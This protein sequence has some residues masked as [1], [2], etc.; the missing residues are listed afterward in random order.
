L[1]SIKYKLLFFKVLLLCF[2]SAIFASEFSNI[3]KKIVITGKSMEILNSGNILISKG[4]SKAVRG[5]N[6]LRA[7]TMIYDKKKSIV[8]A[9]GNV[10]LSGKTE[11]NSSVFAEGDNAVYDEK[12]ETGKFFGKKVLIKY[13]VKNS[14][15]P[16]TLSAKKIVID[17]KK[18][19]ITAQTDVEIITSSGTIRSDNAV[20]IKKSNGLIFRKAEKRPTVNAIYEDKTGDY[21][22]D[23]IV[24][25]NSSA[26]KKIVMSGS[27][28][29][30]IKIGE[31]DEK[32]EG[33]EILPIDISSNSTSSESIY[34]ST[35]ADVE[36][37]LNE[38]KTG[39]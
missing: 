29:G 24:L 26:A 25:Y 2:C 15:Q 4:N 31:K 1:K 38:I 28:V 13:L 27:V 10:R 20:Y 37:N 5:S 32:N 14:S 8:S 17:R 30:K 34:N 21:E 19:I 23:T 39:Q 3:P 16:V 18:E 22:A 9:L 33:D 11:D 6:V 36:N 12:S 35:A 7:D